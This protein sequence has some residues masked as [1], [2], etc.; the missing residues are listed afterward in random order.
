MQL[1][2][3]CFERPEKQRPGVGRQPRSDD[4]HAVV[5]AVGLDVAPLQLPRREVL[6]L[7]ATPPRR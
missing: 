1:V 7:G 4:Q 2:F 3:R 5:V 6:L